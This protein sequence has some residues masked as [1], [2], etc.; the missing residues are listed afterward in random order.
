MLCCDHEATGP[1]GALCH[2]RLESGLANQRRLLVTCNAIY[3]HLAAETI[4]TGHAK[5]SRTVAHLGQ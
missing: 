1:I 2:A 4:V 3:G 5:I